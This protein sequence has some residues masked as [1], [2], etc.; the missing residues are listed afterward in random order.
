MI[1]IIQ[2]CVSTAIRVCSDIIARCSIETTVGKVC[3]LSLNFAYAFTVNLTI[4]VKIGV[5]QLFQILH[6][7]F[8]FCFSNSKLTS[9]PIYDCR[10]MIRKFCN[11]FVKQDEAAVTL[12]GPQG[13]GVNVILKL[14]D[15]FR[16]FL[17]HICINV[18]WPLVVLIIITEYLLN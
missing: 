6:R 3:Y 11:Y 9:R 13:F 17:S 2:S 5:S 12:N 16:F 7:S 4:T 18:P 15:I 10:K 8:W 1:D 14:P